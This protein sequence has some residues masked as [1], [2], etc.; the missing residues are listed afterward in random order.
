MNE[1]QYVVTYGGREW[2]YFTA[3]DLAEM[4]RVPGAKNVREERPR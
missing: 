2:G 4:G 1:I 3:E